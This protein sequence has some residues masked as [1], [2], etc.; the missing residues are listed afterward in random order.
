MRMTAVCVLST[1]ICF[2]LSLDAYLALRVCDLNLS[3]PF[4]SPFS[5]SFSELP[6]APLA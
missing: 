3:I 2:S 1:F 4:C 6:R 5:F